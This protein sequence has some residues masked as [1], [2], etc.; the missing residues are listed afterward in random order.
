MEKKNTEVKCHSYHVMSR[1]YA[2]RVNLGG[3]ADAAFA[4]FLHYKVILPYFSCILWNQATKCGPHMRDKEFYSTFLKGQNL[5]K[6]FDFL[7]EDLSFL[8][9]FNHLNECWIHF[10]FGVIISRL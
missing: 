9:H 5:L 3:P 7:M 1:V 4:R 10:L 2:D 6:L 8:P